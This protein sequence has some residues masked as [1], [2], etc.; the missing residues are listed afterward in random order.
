MQHFDRRDW[1]RF[2]SQ[3]EI[4]GVA[5]ALLPF[6]CSFSASS[7]H[8][9]N[10]VTVEKSSTDFVA[11]AAGAVAIALGLFVITTLLPQTAAEDR[12]KRLAVV[13]LTLAVGVFQVLVRG[14][15]VV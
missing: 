14:L 10:G 3:I 5:A 4:A 6:V 12:F 7:S 11:I 2:P 15:S 8:T 1:S 13:A 9:V